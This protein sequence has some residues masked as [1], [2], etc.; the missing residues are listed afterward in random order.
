MKRNFETFQEFMVG[1]RKGRP[2]TNSISRKAMTRTRLQSL[3][4][5]GYGQGRDEDYKSW[6]R[7]TRGNAPR[8]SNHVVAVTNIDARP[9]HTLSKMEHNALHLALWFGAAEVREQ[10]PIWPWPGSPH[11]M[12]GLDPQR[13]RTLPAAPG[14]LEIAA[15]A[16]IPHGTYVGA[17][18]LPY[19]ATT[20]LVIRL[21]APPNDRL[22]FWSCKPADVLAHRKDGPRAKQRIELERLYAKAIGAHHAVYDG[23][24]APGDLLANLD[25]LEPPRS[26][27]RDETMAKCRSAFAQAFNGT[28]A[29][30]TVEERIQA[31]ATGLDMELPAAQQHFRAVAWQGAIDADLSFPIVM[32]RTLT[33]GG[34]QLKR[35]LFQ[36]LMGGTQ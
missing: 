20:D 17:P 19:V 4:L 33:T 7:V 15:E 10:F 8:E 24:Q 25:W 18:E 36:Q 6:I 2:L 30:S 21:G 3:I 32:S 14:L 1:A 35:A 12:A 11:P 22:V 29:D 27:L 23:T 34:N 16:G 13:D 5:Q 26:E 28:S 31:V 9:V